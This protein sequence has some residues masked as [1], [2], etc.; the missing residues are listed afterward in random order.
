[1]ATVIRGPI[2]VLGSA[3][4]LSL[5]TGVNGSSNSVDVNKYPLSNAAD[6]T[7]PLRVFRTAAAAG[8][9]NVMYDVPAGTTLAGCF[10]DNVNFTGTVRCEYFD[11][12]AGLT[13]KTTIAAEEGGV[14]QQ[15]KLTGRY[16]GF[17]RFTTPTY[18]DGTTIAK[19][20]LVATGD[21][22]VLPSSPTSNFQFGAVT[23]YEES[24]EMGLPGGQINDLEY[25]VVDP[26]ILN[27]FPGGA[28][29]PIQVGERFVTISFPS[30][31]YLEESQTDLFDILLNRTAP[32]IYYENTGNIGKAYT[33]RPVLDKAIKVK[34]DI[35]GN[36]FSATLS[37][38][39][40]T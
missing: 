23:F 30:R 19:V 11:N 15:D 5:Y 39:E 40:T 13:S 10:V 29:E 18:F 1:M 32:I 28:T 24:Q 4:G 9:A 22:V 31:R 35:P 3:S 16:K 6:R 7:H 17:L 8:S 33:T 20:R 25:E 2:L 14:I 21:T 12:A 38:I 37:L 27:K 36:V 34:Y 26:Q